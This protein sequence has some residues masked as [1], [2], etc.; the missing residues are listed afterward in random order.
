[1]VGRV[2]A[3]VVMLTTIGCDR[4]TK[5][6]ATTNLADR[7]A[8]AYLADNLR[9]EYAE[10]PGAFLSLGSRLPQWVRTS[11]FKVGVGFAL[12]AISFVALKHRWIGSPLVGASLV[13]AGG[14]SNLVDRIA[15][16]SVVD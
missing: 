7:P 15:R 16:G 3:L 11:L 1:M 8:Q 4:V 5:H 13:F 9:F 10:N 6:L 12:A 2:F 14:V